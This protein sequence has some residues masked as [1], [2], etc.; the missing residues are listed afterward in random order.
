MEIDVYTT[1]PCNKGL[2]GR[3]ALH[4]TMQGD[5][6]AVY[7][8]VKCVVEAFINAQNLA[9]ANVGKVVVIPLRTEYA[10]DSGAYER[11]DDNSERSPYQAY[12]F[13]DNYPA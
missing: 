13:G 9:S 11:P 5:Q 4:A 7:I 8:C 3:A 10:H 1:R 2:H 6:C 12:L